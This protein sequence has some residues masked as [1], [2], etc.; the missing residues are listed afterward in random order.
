MKWSK[1]KKLVEE[2]FSPA[3]AG[4]VSIYSTRYGNCTCGRAWLTIDGQEI[5]NF[6]TRALANKE[7]EEMMIQRGLPPDPFDAKTDTPFGY[8]E[9]SRQDAYAAC[10]AFVH[11]LSVEQAVAD[12]D[13][14][15]QTLAVL[16]SR[17][18]K[19]RLSKLDAANMH[20]L[21]QK[22]LLVR[23]EAEGLHR[24]AADSNR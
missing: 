2:R 13:P 6:C 19:R 4:R 16:D 8:G 20:P 1:L 7:F 11:D 18:G 17:L 23:M 3:L 14:L 9:L 15:V 21:A 22:M 5:A 24:D 10:W 12:S